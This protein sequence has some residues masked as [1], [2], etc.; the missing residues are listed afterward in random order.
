MSMN[1]LWQPEMVQLEQMRGVVE[2]AT[3]VVVDGAGVESPGVVVVGAVVVRVVVDAVAGVLGV[4][5]VL[6]VFFVVTVVIVV[7]VR[8]DARHGHCS[9]AWNRSSNRNMLISSAS[10]RMPCSNSV[11]CHNNHRQIYTDEH[12]HTLRCS[13]SWPTTSARDARAATD[14]WIPSL[15]WVSVISHN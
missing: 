3:V 2:V 1:D 5:T 15:D 13:T 7:V 11:F 9:P 12:T 4:V 8:A 14:A 10:R 6:V